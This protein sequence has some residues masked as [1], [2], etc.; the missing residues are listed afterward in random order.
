[1][2]DAAPTAA[3]TVAARQRRR[4]LRQRQGVRCISGEVLADLVGALVE[5]DWLDLD[6]AND[7]E[8]L[9]AALVDLADCWMRE[10]LEPP[11]S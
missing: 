4:R 10:T 9:G 6:D 11:K 5:N 2:T 3:A 7:P 1:M 8:K